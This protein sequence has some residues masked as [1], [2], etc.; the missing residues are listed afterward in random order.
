MNVKYEGKDLEAMFFA[1]NYHRWV[2]SIFK[3]YLGKKIAEVGAGSGNVSSMLLL[4]KPQ[5]LVVVEP[6]DDMY[7]KLKE[8]FLQNSSVVTVHSLFSEVYEK[9][10]NYFDSVVYVNVLEHVEHDAQELRYIHDS[11]LPG[12]HVCIFVPALPSLYSEFD[13]SIGHYR[14]Y[15]K[16]GLKKILEESGFE[17]VKITYFDFIGIIPWFIVFK[18]FRKKLSA[19]NTSAYDRFVVPFSKVVESILPVPVGKNIVAIARKK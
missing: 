17:I 13:A 16:Q 6:S 7:P 10:K 4:E 5:E 19:G 8:N 9:Y 3:P 12:G 14:R 2:I 15:T 1:Q 11:L 18:L